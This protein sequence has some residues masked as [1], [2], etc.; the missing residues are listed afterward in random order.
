VNAGT[1]V[2]V[3]AA[4]I[5]AIA[6]YFN[7]RSTRA[8][9]RAAGAAE[10]QTA[11]QRQLR[12]DA[13][14]PYVWVDV[15]PDGETGTLLNLTIGNSGPT[16][17][18][19]VRI[20]VDPP[21]PAIDQ[22]TERAE[23]AQTA[24]ADGISSLAPGR[25]L[26]WP[27]GQAFNLIKHDGR[28]AHTFTVNADGPFGAMSPLTYTVDL[29]DLRGT[30]DRPS[31]L[32]RLTKAVDSFAGK[33]DRLTKAVEG[34]AEEQP[35]PPHAAAGT[36]PTGSPAPHCRTPPCAVWVSLPASKV[37]L[38]RNSNSPQ[39][40]EALLTVPPTGGM[41][42]MSAMPPRRVLRLDDMPGTGPQCGGAKGGSP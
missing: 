7:A 22:L 9:V 2:A 33:L 8:A 17:A 6:A 4:V 5:A 39:K 42:A 20:T 18:T 36:T 3:V 16:V 15:R 40:G 24:L 1:W 32:H 34:L 25:I 10:E 27:L 12:I 11:V 38:K 14:Q 19:N 30:L 35:N 13:A 29:A 23:A 26:A 21:L 37:M 31:G 41:R 28:Q